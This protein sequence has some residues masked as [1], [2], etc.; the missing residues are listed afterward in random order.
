MSVTKI[1]AALAMVLT[2]ASTNYAQQT[3]NPALTKPADQQT[4]NYRGEAGSS[5]NKIHRASEV[6]GLNV[7]TPDN[8]DTIGEVNDLVLDGENGTIRYAAVSVGGFLGI[9]DTMV[10]VPWKAFECRK[11]A[12]G[13][14]YLSLDTTKEKLEKAPGFNQDNWPDFG[15]QQWSTDN[16]RNFGVSVDINTNR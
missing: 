6:I 8:E 9:G 11:D 10:A 4:A 16:D 12:D 14:S 1:L 3:A 5:G 7:M 15:N 13:N 2:C